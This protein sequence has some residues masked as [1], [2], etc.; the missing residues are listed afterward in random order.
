M[1]SE[2]LPEE[3]IERR[4]L[5]FSSK[6]GRFERLVETVGVQTSKP[7]KQSLTGD[8]AVLAYIAIANIAFHLAISGN[9]GYFRDEL[10]YIVNG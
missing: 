2:S 4:K 7:W 5:L 8:V 10:Y 1:G 3:E 9:Y 6:K